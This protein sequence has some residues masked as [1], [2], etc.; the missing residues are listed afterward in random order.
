MS[1]P[2]ADRF[3]DSYTEMEAMYIYCLLGGSLPP[4][5]PKGDQKKQTDGQIKQ[6][7]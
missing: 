6:H 4:E 1:D 5:E 2:D 3:P 7:K